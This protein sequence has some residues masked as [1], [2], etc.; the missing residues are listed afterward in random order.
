[1]AEESFRRLHNIWK[2]MNMCRKTSY[3]RAWFFPYSFMDVRLGSNH[4]RRKEDIYLY[5]QVPQNNSQ[6]QMV[7]TC[8]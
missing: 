2:A 8:T 3:L 7:A 5:D 1:M 6:D 4:D